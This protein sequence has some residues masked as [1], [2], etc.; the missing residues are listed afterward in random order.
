MRECYHG[1]C[2][3][4]LYN[5]TQ[6]NFASMDLLKKVTQ[7]AIDMLLDVSGAKC[8]KGR[9]PKRPEAAA[10]HNEMKSHLNFYDKR[11]HEIIKGIDPF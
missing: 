8:T 3:D 1:P 10:E 5:R 4:A 7:T 6:A 2:D 11:S 9:Y